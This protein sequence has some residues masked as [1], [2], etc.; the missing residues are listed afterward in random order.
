MRWRGCWSAGMTRP[1]RRVALVLAVVAGLLA[2]PLAA[3]ATEGDPGDD[4]DVPASAA[5]VGGGEA[6]AGEYPFVAGIL[7]GSSAT[8]FD[9]YELQYCGATIVATRWALTAAHCIVGSNGLPVATTA[10][11]V[12]AGSNELVYGTG[13]RIDVSQI[14]VHPEYLAARA[15]NPG[16]SGPFADDVALLRLA[17][18]APV[19]AVAVAAPGAPATPVGSSAT[20]VGWGKTDEQFPG[21]TNYPH[22]LYHVDMSVVADDDPAPGAVDCLAVTGSQRFVASDMLCA[23]APGADTCTGDSGGPLL[24]RQGDTWVQIGVTSYGYNDPCGYFPGGYAEI[25]TYS[26]W[27]H[28]FIDPPPPTTTTTAAATTTTVPPPGTP[29]GDRGG[30][31]PGYWMLGAD[32]A[33]YAF[34]SAQFLPFTGAPPHDC[35]AMAATPD[36]EGYWLL[37]RSGQVHAY[38]DAVPFGNATPAPGSSAAGISS[39][40]SGLGYW[41]VDSTGN[42][43]A[44]GD[45][46]YHGGV[47]N[48]ALNSPVISMTTAPDGSGYWLLAADGGVFTF[49]GARFWGST[50][51]I[52]L[53]QPVVSMAATATGNGYWLVASDGGVFAFGDA[54]FFGSMGGT[55]LNRP[56][57]G[58]SRTPS[59]AGYWMVA[60]DGG[61]FA[62]GDASFV[63]SLGATP[64]SAPV[65]GLEPSF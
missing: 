8:P 19:A 28:S 57:N 47:G 52:R 48:L 7:Y 25:A 58:L 14:V 60:S 24:A 61:V 32:C 10:V 13:H 21:G 51:N 12:W 5:I 55:T 3:W 39:T 33:L 40:S 30:A 43:S 11:D 15:A 62:F 2:A 6:P 44:F 45:A 29:P 46:L 23:G 38:G 65:V 27:I 49:G 20:A 50:G 54:A 31:Q 41:V 37:D 36:G 16:S 42:V 18:D 59:G 56:V 34:G 63:G 22:A 64:I 35:V 1:L 4:D 9:P 53:N 17:A 26:S